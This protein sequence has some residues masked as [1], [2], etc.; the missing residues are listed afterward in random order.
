MNTKEQFVITISREIGRGGHTVGLLL[1]Q[2]LG[3]RFCDKELVNSLREK[4]DLTVYEIERLKGEK[5]NWLTSLFAKLN[6]SPVSV[7]KNDPVGM[8]FDKLEK[9]VTTDDVYK[10]E[11]EILRGMA[12]ESSCVIAGRSG[13]FVLENH[14]NKFDIFLTSSRQKRI[15]R[16]MR[17]QDLNEETARIIVDE[18]DKMRDNY[19]KRY[20][21][22]SRYDLRNYDLCL[23]MDDLNEEQAV[24]IILKALGRK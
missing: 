5:K 1:A 23:N 3:V 18:I 20:T 17:K 4:F 21:D 10:A 19:V 16:V 24:E 14:P 8:Y 15:E 13:F 22:K 9:E 6:P 12:A 7:L 2:K 11:C